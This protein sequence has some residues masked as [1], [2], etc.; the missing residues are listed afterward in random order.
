MQ[1]SNLIKNK[2]FWPNI[3]LS[4]VEILVKN[5]NSAKVEFFFVKNFW[6]NIFLS[7]VEILVKNGNSAKVEFFFCQKFS[8]KVTRKLANNYSILVNLNHCSDV[9]IVDSKFV[10]PKVDFLSYR[11]NTQKLDLRRN[12]NVEEKQNDAYAAKTDIDP[13]GIDAVFLSF[14]FFAVQDSGRGLTNFI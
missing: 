14:D 2:K 8:A 9:K 3:F 12:R 5:R 10:P 7:K 13:L 1:K 6:P 11:L 4:K